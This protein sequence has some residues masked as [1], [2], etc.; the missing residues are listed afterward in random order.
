MKK[1]DLEKRK[2]IIIE[3]LGKER[4]SNEAMEE[5][6]SILTVGK[7]KEIIEILLNERFA[8]LHLKSIGDVSFSPNDSYMLLQLARE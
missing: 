4:F 2:E 1:M 6:A 3:N 7:S 5:L 8:P